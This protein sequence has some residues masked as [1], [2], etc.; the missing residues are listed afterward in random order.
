MTMLQAVVNKERNLVMIEMD[1]LHEFFSANKDRGF[2][3]RVKTNTQRYIKL[4][5]SVID[6]NLP[7]PS[8]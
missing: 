7:L 6:S 4:F 3:D 2:I 5:S 1:D 8:V